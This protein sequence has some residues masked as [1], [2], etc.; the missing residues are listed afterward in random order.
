M[1]SIENTLEQ[2]LYNPSKSI[3]FCLKYAKSTLII[4]PARLIIVKIQSQ[5]F[6]DHQV[7]YTKMWG[8]F[9]FTTI[10]HRFKLLSR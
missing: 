9:G 7:E 2:P 5:C 10:N 4:F 6:F 1:F 3:Q 8:E